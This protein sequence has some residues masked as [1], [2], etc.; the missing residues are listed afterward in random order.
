MDEA[1]PMRN[2]AEVIEES[3]KSFLFR[4]QV[5]GQ[6]SFRCQL[7]VHESG[8]LEWDG[9]QPSIV[10]ELRQ[11]FK[12]KSIANFPLICLGLLLNQAKEQFLSFQTDEEILDLVNNICVVKQTDPTKDFIIRNR[13]GNGS[14]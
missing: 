6:K 9:L 10:M 3:P 4:H 7:Y 2:F 8:E 11:Q 1:E 13:I 5:D 12:A 14:L